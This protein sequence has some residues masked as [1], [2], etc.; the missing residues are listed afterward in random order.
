[1]IFNAVIIFLLIALLLVTIFKFQDT[2]YIFNIVKKYFF[3]LLFFAVLLFFVFSIIYINNNNKLY[4][5]S[6][7]G[8]FNAGKVYISWR[9]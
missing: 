3:V 8:V 7:K 2:I 5:G 4:Y 6:L 1:M 9:G